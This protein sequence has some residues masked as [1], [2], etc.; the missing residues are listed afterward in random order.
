MKAVVIEGPG[1]V[2]LKEMNTPVVGPDDVL[3]RAPAASSLE[4]A[5]LLEPTAVVAHAFL[6][7]QP[8]AGSTVVVIGDGNIGLLAIQIA[9]LFSPAQLVLIGSRSERLA[10]GERLGATHTI[11]ARQ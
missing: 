7:A 9:R 2:S 10:L 4:E 3:I 6:R 5:G 1:Q 11:N 8:Q